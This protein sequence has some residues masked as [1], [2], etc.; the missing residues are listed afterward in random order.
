MEPSAPEA[1]KTAKDQSILERVFEAGLWNARLVVLLAVICGTLSAI[2]L[3]VAGSAEII[4][5]LINSAS[6]SHLEFDY[7][8]MLKGIIGGVDLYLIGMV[9]LIFSFGIYGT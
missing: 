4:T 6:L 3:F 8:Q 5:C 2:A 1:K 9:L 7:I